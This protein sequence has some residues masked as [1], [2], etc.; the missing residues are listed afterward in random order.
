VVLHAGIGKEPRQ[1]I[2]RAQ[3][4]AV[5][6]GHRAPTTP[7]EITTRHRPRGSG[8]NSN[9]NATCRACSSPH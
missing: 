2:P 7:K 1:E 4:R 3:F 8:R 6:C 9:A 5:H